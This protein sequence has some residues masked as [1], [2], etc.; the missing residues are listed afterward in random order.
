[1]AN[2]WDVTDKDIDRFAE[3]LLQ[4]W[5]QHAASDA[6]G[7]QG[8]GAG[9]AAVHT[10]LEDARRACKLRALTGAAPVCYGLPTLLQATGELA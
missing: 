3:A 2:L 6:G 9:G 10:G 1:M 5:L 8:P 7:Q 4:A